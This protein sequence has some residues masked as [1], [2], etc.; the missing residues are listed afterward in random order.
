MSAKYGTWLI[1]LIYCI[2]YAG[3]FWIPLPVHLYTSFSVFLFDLLFCEFHGYSYFYL[4]RESSSS[5]L[6]VCNVVQRHVTP[7]N[8]V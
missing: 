6:V 7:C 4:K 1:L 5:S 2:G 8:V 3:L